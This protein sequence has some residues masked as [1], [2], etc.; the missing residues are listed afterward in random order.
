MSGLQALS[1]IHPNQP[2]AM[3]E[4]DPLPGRPN[5]KTLTPSGFPSDYAMRERIFRFQILYNQRA[6]PFNGNTPGDHLE[7][8]IE[9]LALYEE[10]FA[11]AATIIP[12]RREA[13]E[14]I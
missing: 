12:A 2:P 6:E 7:A 5:P 9:P 8:Y 4:Q 13:Q 14:I 11:E 3:A 1:R 10:R